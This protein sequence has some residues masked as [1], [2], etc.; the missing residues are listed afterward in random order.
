MAFTEL[1]N[2]M[3]HINDGFVSGWDRDRRTSIC[4]YEDKQ[5]LALTGN[6]DLVVYRASCLHG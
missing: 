5:L 3:S 4:D 6:L 1:Q 2:R